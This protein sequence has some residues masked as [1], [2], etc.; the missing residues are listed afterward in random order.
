[1]IEERELYNTLKVFK[2]MKIRFT[3]HQK[4]NAVLLK[5]VT[6]KMKV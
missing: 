1:M 2:K 6:T 5:Q 3:Q 4:D